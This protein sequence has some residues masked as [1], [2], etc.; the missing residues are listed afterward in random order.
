[1]QLNVI[2]GL[3]GFSSL[4]QTLTV[5]MKMNDAGSVGI[6]SSSLFIPNKLC[7]SPL[8][9]SFVIAAHNQMSSNTDDVRSS[10]HSGLEVVLIALIVVM[11]CDQNI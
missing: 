7:L 9:G 3:W 8:S 11:N 1:M 2:V 6:T 10:S 4:C 5:L